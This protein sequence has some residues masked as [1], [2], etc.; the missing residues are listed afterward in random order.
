MGKTLEDVFLKAFEE[1]QQKLVRICSVYSKNSEDTKDLLQEVLINIWKSMPSFKA[2]S[3]I[4]T[5]M[6][7]ITLNTCLRF[8]SNT[9]KKQKRF[10]SMDSIVIVSAQT[11]TKHNEL[12]E[13]LTKLRCCINELNKADRAIITLYLEKVP[14]KDISIITGLT[15]NHIA[16][17]IKRIKL[18]LLNCIN[19]QS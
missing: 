17:K 16:V 6:Y 18:K 12:D 13:K 8:R 9:I 5:W 4:D 19:E 2:E 3:S 11:E 15:E 10:I 1:N 14:Y 7:R